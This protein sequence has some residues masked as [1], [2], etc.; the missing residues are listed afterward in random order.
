MTYSV[1][2]YYEHWFETMTSEEYA[3]ILKE[4]DSQGIFYS[5]NDEKNLGPATTY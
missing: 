4:K 1:D 5:V 2:E 3:E